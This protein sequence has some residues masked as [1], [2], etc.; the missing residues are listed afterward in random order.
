MTSE[1]SHQMRA[2][3]LN[4]GLPLTLAP[5]DF[6]SPICQRTDF[7]S[8]LLAGGKP[9]EVGQSIAR[10]LEL[11]FSNATIVCILKAA[12]Q[13]TFLIVADFACF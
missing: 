12:R 6:S 10:P 4:F 1:S 9:F 5:W 7:R 11:R 8:V 13:G 3:A 2:Q